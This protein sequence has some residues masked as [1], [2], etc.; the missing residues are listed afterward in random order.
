M[1]GSR[2]SALTG[3]WQWG[4]RVTPLLAVICLLLIYFVLQEPHRGEAENAHFEK[5]SVIED[6]KYLIKM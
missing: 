6:I 3:H 1:L 2:V 4:V 5:T